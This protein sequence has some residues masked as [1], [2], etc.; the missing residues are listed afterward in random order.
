MAIDVLKRQGK[1]AVTGLLGKNLRRVAG[2]IGSVMRGDEGSESS[3]TAALNR[4]K[5]STKMLSFPIDVGAD[6]G[7]GNN[8]HYIMFFINEQTHAKLKFGNEA[9]ESSG[10]ETGVGNILGEAQIRKMIGLEKIFNEKFGGFVGN[11]V[12]DKIS[13]YFIKGLTDTTMGAK[14]GKSGRIKTEVKHTNKEAHRINTTVNVQR[15]ATTRLDTAISMYMPMSVKVKYNA[16]YEDIKMGAITGET[17]DI[18]DTLMNDGTIEQNDIDK[19][20]KEGGAAMEK[21]ITKMIGNVPGLGG[22]RE[23]AEMRKG[24]IYA[25]RFELAFKGI[26]KRTFQYEFKMIPR[27]KDEA[28]EIK[29]IINAFKLNMLPEFANSGSNRSGRSM[30]IPNTFD[31]QYMYQN[32]ENNYLHKI[33][34]CYL[35]SMDVSYGGSRYKTFDG[36]AD[37]A[38]PVETSISLT[39][40]EI[41]LITRER[42][43]EGF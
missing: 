38:P 26:D 41:E 43:L 40:K 5:Q 24:V 16:K 39:F 2:N 18:A 7:I 23:A 27:S 28:D 9:G 20:A 36:N 10:G 1:S 25:D 35:Q 19:L 14:S 21:T 6:P 8:G 29:K 33:S 34:T 37:G 31:I 42:A 22:L 13:K 3:E 30:T 15:K 17:M 11:F 4:S 12:P 32:A